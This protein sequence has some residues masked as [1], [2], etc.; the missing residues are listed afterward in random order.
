M[1]KFFSTIL[2]IFFFALYCIHEIDAHNRE[3]YIISALMFIVF[4]KLIDLVNNKYFLLI[5]NGTIIAFS[6]FVAIK[7]R[8]FCDVLLCFLPLLFLMTA[9]KF[10]TI[11]DKNFYK[12]FLLASSVTTFVYFVNYS[13][14]SIVHLFFYH[15]KIQALNLYL[16]IIVSI[17]AF[18]IYLFVRL[19]TDL[20]KD[21][22]A[23]CY[24][25]GFVLVYLLVKCLFLPNSFGFYSFFNI[26]VVVPLC[27]FIYS[28]LESENKYLPVFKFIESSMRD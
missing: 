9:N 5:A 24:V 2:F 12:L 6:V 1:K 3:I 16:I 21:G 18:C 8:L 19:K 25:F 7:L 17:I 26:Y 20:T 4:Y 13:K 27:V 11:K 23:V 15:D 22:L 14:E 28:F 10:R